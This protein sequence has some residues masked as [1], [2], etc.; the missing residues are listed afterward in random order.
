MDKCLHQDIHDMVAEV[1]ALTLEKLNKLQQDHP[2]M[3]KK[4]LQ[5]TPFSLRYMESAT[6]DVVHWKSTP[7]NACPPA[8]EQNQI[9]HELGKK[10][11]GKKK[12]V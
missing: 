1:S 9:L 5:V 2:T 6:L 3:D 10:P 12:N 4:R 11:K 8:L 7:N